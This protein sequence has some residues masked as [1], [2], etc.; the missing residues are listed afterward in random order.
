MSAVTETGLDFGGAGSFARACAVVVASIDPGA[1]T[2]V[3]RSLSQVPST[4]KMAVAPSCIAS[5]ML[6]LT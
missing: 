6:W 4:L 3:M 1:R 5:V 2:C